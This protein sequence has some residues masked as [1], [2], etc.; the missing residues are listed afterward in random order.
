MSFE[1]PPQPCISAEPVVLA[2]FCYPLLSPHPLSCVVRV[3]ASARA[4]GNDTVRVSVSCQAHR[5]YSG[6]FLLNIDVPLLYTQA[7]KWL[8]VRAA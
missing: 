3:S 8:H 4:A 5:I 7:G 1:P 2:V 6:L